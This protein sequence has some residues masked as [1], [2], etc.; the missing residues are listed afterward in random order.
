MVDVDA[1]TH[2]DASTVVVKDGSP[3]GKGYW[4][5]MVS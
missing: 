2:I 5:G 3:E 4:V 1:I